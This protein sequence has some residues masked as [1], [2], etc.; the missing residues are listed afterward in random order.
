MS[1]LAAAA[2]WRRGAAVSASAANEQRADAAAH[3]T[4]SGLPLPGQWA[5]TPQHHAPPP[6]ERSCDDAWPD[7]RRIAP[8]EQLLSDTSDPE[9]P[10]VI[11]ALFSFH[12]GVP[13][14]WVDNV[15]A[16]RFAKHP[17]FRAALRFSAARADC[18]APLPPG[19][20]VPNGVVHHEPPADSS[21]TPSA[22]AAAFRARVDALASTP[23]PTDCALWT[24]HHFPGFAVDEPAETD[25]ST[26][27][28]RVHHV[29]GDGVSLVKYCF[30]HVA[31]RRADSSLDTAALPKPQREAAA[32]GRVPRP[33]VRPGVMGRCLQAARD[34]VNVFCGTFVP[35]SRSVLNVA[36]LGVSKF[37]HFI[38]PSE[39]PLA[40]VKAASRRLGV[41]INELFLASLTGALR[42]YMLRHNG[43]AGFPTRF[44]AAL[45]YN[46][47]SVG[48][49]EVNLTNKVVIL[50]AQIHLN[51]ADAMTRLQIVAEENAQLKAGFKPAMA[52]V[53]FRILQLVPSV[54][55]VPMWRHMTRR[56]SV[57]WTN[58]PGPV[59]KVTVDGRTV[60]SIAFS[61]PASGAC[62]SVFSLFSY[63]GRCSLCI[64][65]DR[66]R[67]TFPE[68]LVSSFLRELRALIGPLKDAPTA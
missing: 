52:T 60:D 1:T 34:A 18:F 58:V 20:Y 51:E 36:P 28:L 67:V 8:L 30:L 4:A 62:G 68:E 64:S 48:T 41:T 21:A 7:W 53:A 6:P 65:G 14:A 26:V 23:L 42:E 49:Q 13:A 29:V 25:A 9:Q 43:G 45:A 54:L 15:F 38:P 24:V 17:R 31:D 32:D 33:A 39:I 3:V 59:E 27:V 10:P 50:P 2:F 47:H 46:L 40:A 19:P 56:T 5:R 55:R 44:H 63:A 22:R 35:D 66:Q 16:V 37:A 12:A 57:V 61:A 11:T